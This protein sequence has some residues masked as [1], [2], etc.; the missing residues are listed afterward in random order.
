[1]A[2]IEPVKL[3]GE[4]WDPSAGRT[5]WK[6]LASASQ[7]ITEELNDSPERARAILNFLI[8][9]PISLEKICRR[10]ELLEWLS[11]PDV[12]NPKMTYNPSWRG[13]RSD[14]SFAGLR[15]WKSQEMLRIGFREI[16]GL[17]GCVD[18]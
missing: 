11:H 17:G 14:L 5:V 10:P 3:L 1:M 7:K 12:Q 18:T 2:E 4:L 8:F 9:S 6:K 16:A 13:D 15:A